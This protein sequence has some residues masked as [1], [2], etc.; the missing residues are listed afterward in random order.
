MQNDF[1]YTDKQLIALDY[2]SINNECETVLY[3]GSAGSGKSFLGCDWQIKRRLKYPGT[4]G[5]IG[6]C[7]LKKL[8]LSTMKTFYEVAAGLGLVANK[9][10]TL[11]GQYHVITFSNKSE[12]ILMDLA[13]IPSDPEF[14]RFGSIEITD[15]FVDEAGEVSERCM[16]I[17]DSRVRFKLVNGKPKGIL[18]ANP[19][20][21][22]LY[23][24][25]YDPF[26]RGTL[27]EHLAFVPALPHDNP[28]LDP[29]YIEKLSRLPEVDRKR[30]LEGDWDYDE[31]KDRIFEYQDLLIMCDSSD[32]PNGEMYTTADIGAMGDDPSIVGVWRGLT[33]LKVYKFQ[34]KLPHEIAG[35]IRAINQEWG[36][37]MQK[38]TV[39]SDGLGIGVYGILKCKQFLNGSSAHDKARFE[40][41]RSECYYKL[42][43]LVRLNKVQVHDKSCGPVIVKE[44]DA[45][46]RKNMDKEGKLGIIPREQIIKTLGHSPDYA[47][48]MMM[49]MTFELKPNEGKYAV[50]S[51]S[52]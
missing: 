41:L 27:P 10:F 42:A 14:Q 34:K 51:S 37:G 33:L 38:T 20:K 48:M 31:S 16:N 4:R 35:E 30:L 24:N 21:G 36:V 50:V 32:T 1:Q 22:F 25:F 26:T 17:L 9:H 39:D 3:G 28:H 5:L 46:R 23:R 8:M 15:Y 29:A 52:R 47:S 7:E 2:L 18:T 40:N 43:D 44:L 6:R 13:D 19:S 11:N 49:R 12:I 45:I